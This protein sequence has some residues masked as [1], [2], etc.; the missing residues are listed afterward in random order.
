MRVLIFGDVHGNL[1]ALERMLQQAGS[2]VDLLVCHGDVVNYG[3]WSNECVQLLQSINCTC[4]IGNHESY[5]LEGNYPGENK[6]AKAFFNHCY[7]SFQQQG[8]ISTYGESIQIGNFQVQHTINGQ[9]IFPDTDANK[10]ELKKDYIIGHSHHQFSTIT[11]LGRR[12]VN[13]GSVGQNRKFINVI[14]Y[15]IYETNKPDIQLET[16]VYDVDLVIEEM[17]QSGYPQIC[18][19]YYLQKERL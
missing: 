5:F 2:D 7:P 4:L 8:V 17:K 19:D 12:L 1:V 15:I 16:L 13:T 18:L 11:T 10:L 9:Y 3:P 14:N 6:V